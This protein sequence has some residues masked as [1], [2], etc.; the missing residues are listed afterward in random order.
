MTALHADGNDNPD[1]QTVHTFV[2]NPKVSDTYTQLNIYMYMYMDMCLEYTCTCMYMQ[3]SNYPMEYTV[4]ATTQL[5]YCNL[6]SHWE[7]T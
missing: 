6:S 2:L 7:L 1:Y 4:L 3:Y 5:T